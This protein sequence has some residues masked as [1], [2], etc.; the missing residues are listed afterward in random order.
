MTIETE[1]DIKGLLRIGRI[2]GLALRTMQDRV[3]PG[4]TTKELD[5]I[6]GE[7]L[8][9]NGARSAPYLTYKFPGVTCI[10]IDD[11]AAHG[12]PGDRV[13]RD[14]DLVKID[15]SAERDGYFAD[16]NLT[17]A[18]GEVSLQKQ[19]LL[20]CARLAM[21]QGIQAARA[22]HPLNAIGRAAENIARRHGF[23]VIADLPGHGVGRRLHESPTVPNV[24]IRR[25]NFP[26]H[27][28]LVLTVEPHVA[29]GKGQIVTD[30]D[31][32]TLRTRDHSPVASFEH[33]LVIT[34]GEPILITAVA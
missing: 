33:T 27:S 2:V 30:T 26:L 1:R 14:G 32:W 12:I 23:N 31:G 22:G 16:A 25:A 21:E 28:G 15:V 13:I 24:Y 18:I 4:M 17:V 9:Q 7:F 11:E 29:A 20:D 19:K 34:D 3:R 10:S 8:W 6:G 5:S